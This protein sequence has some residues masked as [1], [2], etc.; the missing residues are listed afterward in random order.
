MSLSIFQQI[1]RIWHSTEF[2]DSTFA[3]RKEPTLITD[4]CPKSRK[5]EW[6]CSVQL[7]SRV[8]LFATPWTTATRPPCPS[9]TTRVYPDPCPLSQWCHPTISF[10]VICF[11]FCPQ[12]FPVSM[13]FPMRWL[14]ASGGQRIGA[15]ASIL[16]MHI[17][18]WFPLG[19]TGLITLLSKGLSRV[20]SITKFQKYRL[21]KDDA[22][23]VLH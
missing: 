21:C 9:P 12:S 18:D 14:F 11:S 3:F 2:W 17:H 8:R 20:F 19:F 7:L 5:G 22:V 6:P 4:I 1:P 16:P 15:L 23:K 13:S 10:S